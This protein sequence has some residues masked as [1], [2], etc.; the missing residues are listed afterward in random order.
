MRGGQRVRVWT[1]F[2]RF[3]GR[4]GELTLRFRWEWLDGFVRGGLTRCRVGKRK[5]EEK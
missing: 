3:A 5:K 1:G 2:G 4:R